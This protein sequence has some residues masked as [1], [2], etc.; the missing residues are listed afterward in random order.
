ML[1]IF[2]KNDLPSRIET[3]NIEYNLLGHAFQSSAGRSLV[4][5]NQNGSLGL[6]LLSVDL[7]TLEVAS[8][9]QIDPPA[10]ALF[11]DVYTALLV[12]KDHLYI[13]TQ[14]NNSYGFLSYSIKTGKFLKMRMITDV[15]NG[16]YAM[17]VED[18]KLYC[19]TSARAYTVD[20]KSGLISS[21]NA[22]GCPGAPVEDGMW[23]SNGGFDVE[24]KTAYSVFYDCEGSSTWF[25]TK[26]SENV[27]S[28]FSNNDLYN[29]Y[30]LQPLMSVKSPII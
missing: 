12:D 27:T 25:N 20:L 24:E 1:Y 2:L 8:L 3:V 22:F 23:Y 15:P 29:V 11:M 9:F 16:C 13:N 6:V 17:A 7:E 30:G 21:F 26:L 28:S 4:L 14:I 5:A 10:G 18:E 19:M